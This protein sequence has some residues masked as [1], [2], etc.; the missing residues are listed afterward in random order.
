MKIHSITSS[1]GGHYIMQSAPKRECEKER[2][3]LIQNDYENTSIKEKLDARA[4]FKGNTPFIHTASLY[5]SRNPLVAEALFALLITCGLRP[6]SIMATASNKGDKDKCTY[7]AAK[8]VSSGLIGLAT[9]VLVAT[10]IAA[11]TKYGLANGLFKMPSKMKTTS[12]EIVKK[13][14]DELKQIQETVKE[15]NP[16]LYE[17]ISKVIDHKEIVSKKVENGKVV[18]KTDSYDILNIDA[19]KKLEDN[20]IDGFKKAIKDVSPN[21][22]KIVNDAIYEQNTQNNYQNTA[23]NVADKFFQPIFMPIRAAI[24]ISAIPPLLSYFG[25]KKSGNKVAEPQNI[26]VFSSLNTASL[27][28]K[29]TKDVFKQFS[30]VTNHAN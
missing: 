2:E 9:T 28:R 5:A 14:I 30:G 18:T 24:T 20:G 10:P 11:A 21:S 22:S 16:K 17:K 19:M 25:L 6:A 27:Q 26:N 4:S 7:Q 1:S 29:N 3:N 8:S 15:S 13:G 12:K 23:K